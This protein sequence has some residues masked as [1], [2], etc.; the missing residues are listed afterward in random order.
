MFKIC[1]NYEK[2]VILGCKEIHRIRVNCG[3]KKNQKQELKQKQPKILT[4]LWLSQ[5]VVLHGSRLTRDSMRWWRWRCRRTGSWTTSTKSSSSSSRTRAL[6]AATR[7]AF[8]LW[9]KISGPAHAPLFSQAWN[10]SQS[11]KQNTSLSSFAV[12]ISGKT[13]G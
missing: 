6:R 13:G 5:L 9:P 7:A 12:P 2:W 8:S 10:S 4:F 3:H 1:Q 11:D